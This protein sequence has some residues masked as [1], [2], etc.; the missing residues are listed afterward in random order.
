MRRKDFG[1]MQCP[2]ARSLERVGEWWSMLIIRDAFAGMTRF[3]EFQKSLGIAPNMLSRRLDALVAAGL[4]VRR[5]YN[6]H[7]IRYE[8]ILTER[9]R[10][11]RPVL[12]MLQ[13]WGSRHFAPEGATVMLVDNETGLPADPVL[14][15]RLTGKPITSAT[16]R[17]VAGPAAGPRM[18]KRLA[19]TAAPEPATPVAATKAR[20]RK[21]TGTGARR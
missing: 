15:D 7:P 16:H 2:V 3:D 1:T 5:P 4:L 14:V 17:N 18:L 6:E 12:L 8:Y 21:R 13:T 11:F 20:P 10:E 19:R 9:G